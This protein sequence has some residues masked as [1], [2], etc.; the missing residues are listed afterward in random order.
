MSP[1]SC[2]TR[3]YNRWSFILL[4]MIK[5]IYICHFKTEQM[6]AISTFERCVDIRILQRICDYIPAHTYWRIQFNKLQNCICGKDYKSYNNITYLYCKNTETLYYNYHNSCL[7]EI[8]TE[9][10]HHCGHPLLV[11]KYKYVMLEEIKGIY[12]K[13]CLIVNLIGWDPITHL[14]LCLLSDI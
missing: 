8:W 2:W 6:Q 3:V 1:H 10:P 11:E 12:D 13:L 5:I 14:T 7:R 4:K 9:S